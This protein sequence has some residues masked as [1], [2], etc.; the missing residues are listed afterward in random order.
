MAECRRRRDNVTDCGVW[1]SY[2]EKQTKKEKCKGKTEGNE[3]EKSEE[4][5]EA[6]PC[7]GVRLRL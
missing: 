5:K 4:G 6:S 7:K 3:E 2:W 1:R